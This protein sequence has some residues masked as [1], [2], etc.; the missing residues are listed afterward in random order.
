MAEVTHRL[1]GREQYSYVEVKFDETDINTMSPEQL[2]S[3]LDGA[4]SDLNNTYP[5]SA[6]SQATPAQQQAPAATGG[7][8]CVHGARKHAK[9]ISAKG[10]WQAYFCTQPKGSQCDAIWIKQGEPG[11]VY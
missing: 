10:P 4:L 5:A 8:A 9:G 7:P 1:P 2:R 6:A 11:W 3:F